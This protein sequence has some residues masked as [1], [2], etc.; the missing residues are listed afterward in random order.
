[1][2]CVGKGGL[3]EKWLIIENWTGIGSILGGFFLL[4]VGHGADANGCKIE[5]YDEAHWE[6]VEM[7]LRLI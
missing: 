5:L 1:M 6:R 2:K 4:L 3:R 7:R